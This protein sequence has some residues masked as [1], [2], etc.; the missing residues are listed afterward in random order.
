[1]GDPG[2]HAQTSQ[3]RLSKRMTCAVNLGE[4]RYTGVVLNVSQGGLFVQTSAQAERGEDVH[5]ELN[6]PGDEQT[7][8]LR[9]EV[10]WRRVV[11]TQL[12]STARGG[13]GVKIVR[14]DETYYNALA[15]WMRVSLDAERATAAPSSSAAEPMP[16]WRVRVRATGT[17]RT[18]CVSV[19]ADSDV[20][21]REAALDYLGEGWQVIGIDSL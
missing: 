11:P 4:R 14:A 8:P 10:V 17:V 9:A 19:E 7:I 3:P 15:D 18:R 12:R 20:A 2:S 21:A 13:M 16:S 6:P 1:M 5:L